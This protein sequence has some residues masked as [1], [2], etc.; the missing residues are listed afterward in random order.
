MPFVN[1]DDFWLVGLPLKGRKRG[2][3]RLKKYDLI[4]CENVENVFFVF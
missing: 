4:S 2:K 3:Q 1:Y